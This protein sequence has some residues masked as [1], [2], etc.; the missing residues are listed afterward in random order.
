MPYKNPKDK[1]EWTKKWQKENR[2]YLTAY[3]KALRENKPISKVQ[4]DKIKKQG[5]T[6]DK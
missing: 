2:E 5:S 3:M 4:F 6:T 1:Q